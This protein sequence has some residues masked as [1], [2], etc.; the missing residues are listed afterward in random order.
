M[1]RFSTIFGGKIGVFLKNQCSDQNFAQ[2][3][4]VLSQKRQLFFA[5]KFGENIFKIITSVPDCA[6]FRRFCAIF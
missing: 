6:N 5:E 3:T 2:F 1:E 4:F